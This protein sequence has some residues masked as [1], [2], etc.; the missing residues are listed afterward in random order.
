MKDLSD[1]SVNHEWLYSLA[2]TSRHTLE[3]DVY[4][5]AV[6][7]RL[8]A[9][10]GLPTECRVCGRTVVIDGAHALCCAS[11]PGTRGHNE[12]RDLLLALARQGDPHAVPEALGLLPAA[13]DL[14][15]ADVL[16]C[17]VGGNGLVALDVG[18]ASPDSQAAVASGDA[19][20]TMRRRKT[21]VYAVHE[22]AMRMCGLT[23]S[24]LG[25]RTRLDHHGIDV[26][27]PPGRP[28]PRRGQMAAGAETIPG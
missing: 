13:P 9:A 7:L 11:G 18:I 15:P 3:P 16:T 22:E 8:G 19:L 12:A 4:V 17:A 6:R 14:R 27:V 2:P 10:G 23:Y 26:A 1:A 25:C 28:T 5:D 21:R 20:E 24:P